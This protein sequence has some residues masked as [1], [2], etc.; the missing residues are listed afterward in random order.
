VLCDFNQIGERRDEGEVTL[1]KLYKLR[2]NP[3]ALA[4][5]LRLELNSNLIHELNDLQEGTF[6][7]DLTA[8]SSRD[9]PGLI[10][11]AQQLKSTKLICCT[12]PFVIPNLCDLSVTEIVKLLR[13]ELLLGVPLTASPVPGKIHI[14]A[15]SVPISSMQSLSPLELKSLECV[16]LTQSSFVDSPH[17][18]PPLFLEFPHWAQNHSQVLQAILSSCP[19]PD[20]SRIVL[21]HNVLSPDTVNYFSSLLSAYPHFTLCIDSFGAVETPPLGQMYPNDQDIIASALSL[22]TSGDHSSR[23]IFSSHCRYKIHLSSY[24]GSGFHHTQSFVA[25][26]LAHQHALRSKDSSSFEV[27]SLLRRSSVLCWY[28]PP[29]PKAPEVETV[30]CVL[31]EKRVPV[32]EQYEKYGKSYCSSRCLSEHRKRGWS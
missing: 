12:G 13:A 16:A 29:E 4:T 32:V 9:L 17:R 8:D 6:V 5:N 28:S 27:A 14:G 31:C 26:R 2:S 23:L 25:Q 19:S 11:L 10:S 24:G 22:M 20:L 1:Q 30:S 21:C 3:G 15:I 18:P 7:V